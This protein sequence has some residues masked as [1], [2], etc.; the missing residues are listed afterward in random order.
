MTLKIIELG[1]LFNSTLKRLLPSSVTSILLEVVLVAGSQVCRLLENM[2]AGKAN[3]REVSAIV[4][5]EASTWV[6]LRD[7]CL[8]TV[9]KRSIAMLHMSL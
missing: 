1:G 7:F 9:M 6:W 2:G 3:R 5:M 8:T 4:E